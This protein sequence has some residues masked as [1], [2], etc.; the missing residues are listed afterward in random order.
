[1]FVKYL[2]KPSDF[3]FRRKKLNR[4]QIDLYIYISLRNG[5]KAMSTKKKLVVFY[6]LLDVT[7][8]DKKERNRGGK[9]MCYN[10]STQNCLART[11][12]H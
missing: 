6:F 4:A 2:Y 5:K 3:F 8:A 7:D 9:T 10:L 12:H 1:M 11:T